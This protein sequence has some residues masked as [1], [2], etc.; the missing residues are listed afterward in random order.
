[1]QLINVGCVSSVTSVADYKQQQDMMTNKNFIQGLEKFVYAMR[2]KPYVAV[3]IA[4]NLS[5]DE[6]MQRKREYEQI[7]TQISPFAN[8][9]MNFTVSD[10]TSES[11]GTSNGITAN[12]SY[13]KTNGTSESTTD[14]STMTTGTSTTKGVTDTDSYTYTDNESEAKGDTHTV[15]T[16][17]GTSRTVSNG[18]N[19]GVYVGGK[20]GPVN[21]GV[22]GGYNHSVAKGTSHTDSVSDSI[23]KTLTH[24]FSKSNGN[25]HSSISTYG[26]NES[27]GTSKSVGVSTNESTAYT[28]GEAFNFISSKTMTD[29]FGTSKGLTLNAQNMTLNMTMQRL[30]QHLQRIEECESFGMWNFAAYFLGETASETETAANIYKSVI[31]GTDSGIERGAINSWHDDESIDMVMTYVRNFLH[32]QFEYRGFSYEGERNIAVN[33]SVLISTNELAIHMGLPRHSVR[34]LPV[35]EHADFGKEVVTYDRCS[36]GDSINLGKIFNMGSTSENDVRLDIDTLSM[37]TFITGST[38]SGKSNTVYELA[39]QLAASGRNYLIIEPAKGEY[40]NVFGL[41]PNVN[42]FGTNPYYSPLLKINPFKFSKGI[43]ILEHIDR[44][45]EIFNVCWPM[46]AAM[47]A[48]LKDALLQAYQVCGWDLVTSENMYSDDLFPTFQD[49]L[50]ELVDVIQD[51]AYSEEVKSN[52][53]GSLVTRVKSLTNGLNG[54][55]FS[56]KEIDN[57]ILFDKKTI[58]DLSRVGS[59]ETKSLIMGILVMRLSEYRMTSDYEMNQPLKHVTILEEAHNILKKTSTEQSMEGANVAGKSVE[60]ISNAIAEMRTYGEGFIIV[61]QS[62]SAVDISAIRNTN[63]KIIMRLP[64]ELDRRMAG[65]SAGL[66][67]EQLD[68]IAKLPKGVAVVYQNDW[69]EPVLCSI[70]KFIGIERRYK[71]NPE[72]REEN[73]TTL[74]KTKI[75][76]LLLKH[77]VNDPIDNDIDE[78]IELLDD[79]DISVKN[80]LVLRKMLNDFKRTDDLPI[81]K[82][83]NFSELSNVVTEILDA[84]LKTKY[85]IERSQDYDELTNSL[86]KYIADE[87]DELPKSFALAALQCLMKNEAVNNKESQDIYAAWITHIRNKVVF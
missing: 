6:L 80:K 51:S 31:A 39:R 57:E 53:M 42:V 41:L 85:A 46:Y 21:L 64:D 3:F 50:S 59:M 15:G 40:K 43:H 7:Y 29:T 47:P 55:I 76:E 19:V 26:T 66:K 34:G 61:D 67:D 65:K 4:D 71:Y 68:E 70:Q 36:K 49:L 82:E 63:T 27:T 5:Y 33:P 79:A 8:M 2:Q 22:S 1:M 81:W 45:V 48:V 35:V 58:I 83:E 78:V 73:S 18:G 87:T 37:H 38:G 14:T 23:S 77:R 10:G 9:Q 28:A 69:V 20:I 17:D 62:P 72:A 13:T 11:Q 60:M 44:L 86:M 25:S 12:L 32:P 74:F 16:A 52:Y 84:S 30:Q 56:A 24:G 75:L 54:Q